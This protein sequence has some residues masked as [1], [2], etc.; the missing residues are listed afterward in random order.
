MNASS[1]FQF[2]SL[3]LGENGYVD[4][5]VDFNAFRVLGIESYFTY[6]LN[7]ANISHFNHWLYGPCI[8]GV[9]NEGINDLI[10]HSYFEKSACIR[11]FYDMDKKKYFN[12][13]EPGFRWPVMAHGTYNKNSQYNA[14]VLE[15]YKEEAI[16]LI[17]GGE[18]NHCTSQ[19][20]MEEIIGFSSAAHMIYID[21][22]VDVLNYKNP[23]TKFLNRIENVIKPNNYSMNNL[24]FN[25][26]LLKTHNGFILDNIEEE[27]AYLYERNDVFTYESNGNG[28][29]SVYYFW[30]SNNQKYYERAYKR[31][32]DAISNIG[33]IIQAITLFAIIINKLYNNYI[34]LC[35]T[36]NLLFSAIDLE[37]Y[38]F[39]K[40]SNKIT[41]SKNKKSIMLKKVQMEEIFLVKRQKRK[42]TKSLIKQIQIYQKLIILF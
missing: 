23:N 4:K 10:T 32:Q 13:G 33:G 20:K 11:K 19:D 6:Y 40:D 37:K 17:F 21:Y 12:L 3:S 30:L 8:N 2:I 22:Y 39:K 38:I 14:I 15:K 41:K 16:N 9:H 5:G 18:N 24:N 35:N 27:E 1:A 34:I 28:I 42:M 29:Y 31:I 36:E 26:I 7:D 25:P